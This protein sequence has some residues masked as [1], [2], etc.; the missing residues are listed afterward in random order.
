MV[1]NEEIVYDFVWITVVQYRTYVYVIKKY[2]NFY[3]VIFVEIIF[4]EVGNHVSSWSTH[5][6][7]LKFMLFNDDYCIN[8]FS[9]VVCYVVISI[10]VRYFSMLQ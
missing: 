1:P 6:T 5:W 8:Y 3:H 4:V 7:A 2:F 10:E 9:F